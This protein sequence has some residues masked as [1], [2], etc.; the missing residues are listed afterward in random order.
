MS[1]R[2]VLPL[3][4]KAGFVDDADGMRMGMAMRDATPEPIPHCGR[5]PAQ[6]CQKLLQGPRRLPGGISQRLDTL[7]LQVTELPGDV[8]LKVSP[9]GRPPHAAVKLVEV[10]GQSRSDPQNRLCVHAEG[11]LGSRSTRTFPR[12]PG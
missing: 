1:I 7:P 6:H 5:I 8:G 12:L 2:G 4:G 11:F 3:L 9:I 10:L